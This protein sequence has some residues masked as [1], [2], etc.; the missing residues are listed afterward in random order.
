MKHI[1]AVILR[2]EQKYLICRRGAG[3]FCAFLWEFP[4]GKCE[5]GETAAACAIREC[6][7]ELGIT[8][9]LDSLYDTVHWRYPDGEL[10]LTFYL[11][12]IVAGE[13]QRRV[14][15]ELRWVEA[16]DLTAFPFCPA[17]V[18]IVDRLAAQSDTKTGS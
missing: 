10:T 13:P 15:T 8:V 18:E 5:P 14:H 17:D 9:A 6:Q 1:S 4:G 7:E 11:G 12:H 16:A 2:Q 3:G